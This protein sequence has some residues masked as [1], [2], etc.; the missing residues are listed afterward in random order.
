M[1]YLQANNLSKQIIIIGRVASVTANRSL[2]RI[3]MTLS[4]SA[5]TTKLIEQTESLKRVADLKT[6]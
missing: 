3:L 5:L 4:K 6:S 1:H 2:Q